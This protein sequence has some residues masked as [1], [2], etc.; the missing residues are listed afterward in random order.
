MLYVI[1]RLLETHY[2]YTRSSTVGISISGTSLVA[3]ATIAYSMLQAASDALKDEVTFKSVPFVFVYSFV[4]KVGWYMGAL[5]MLKAITR[6]E[7]H[8]RKRW[9]PVIHFSPPTHAERSSQRVD[10]RATYR[11]KAIVWIFP[12]H[13]IY[14]IFVIPLYTDSNYPSRLLQLRQPSST[15]SIISNISSSILEVSACPSKAKRS[16]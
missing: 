11:F 16:R 13:I 8:W 1:D 7:L 12:P 14:F 2:W 15:L 5:I 10:A 9:M 3:G 6:A 4:I